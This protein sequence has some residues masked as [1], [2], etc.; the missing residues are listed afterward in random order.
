MTTASADSPCL[1]ILPL[2]NISGSF[3]LALQV[4]FGFLLLQFVAVRLTVGVPFGL[5]R[6]GS[7]APAPPPPPERLGAVVERHAD[8]RQQH[9]E[10]DDLPAVQRV[11]FAPEP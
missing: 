7:G 3:A 10:E 2:P 8:R 1:R 6:V 11:R 9:R 5:G 4:R